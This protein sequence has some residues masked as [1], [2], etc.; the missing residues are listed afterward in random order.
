MTQLR[1]DGIYKQFRLWI[2]IISEK[3]NNYSLNLKWRFKIEDKNQN[4]NLSAI[5]IWLVKS[6]FWR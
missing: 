1:K 3:K 6:G 5:F 2:G 4:I